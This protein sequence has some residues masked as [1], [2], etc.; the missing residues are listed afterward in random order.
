MKQLVFILFG[1]LLFTLGLP[2]KSPATYQV[3]YS[4]AAPFIPD[5]LVDII[6]KKAAQDLG[7][8]YF[9]IKQDY[10]NGICCI[11]QINPKVY[12]VVGGGGSIV[13]IELDDI[14]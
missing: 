7:V 10:Q 13:I 4:F 3:Q 14:L 2:Q 12:K 6:L 8:S 5:A 11:H 9:S 1:V